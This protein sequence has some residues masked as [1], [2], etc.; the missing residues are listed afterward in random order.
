VDGRRPTM[1]AHSKRGFSEVETR[2]EKPI[3]HQFNGGRG[4]DEV[5]APV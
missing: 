1:S 4:E 5:A 3:G 2:D